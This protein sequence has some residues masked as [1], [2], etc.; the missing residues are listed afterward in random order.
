MHHKD[1]LSPNA[2]ERVFMYFCGFHACDHNAFNTSQLIVI[3]TR[4]DRLTNPKQEMLT[5]ENSYKLS[6]SQTRDMNLGMC[7]CIVFK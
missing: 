7:V 5:K 6:Y 3:E 4:E 2:W 1:P